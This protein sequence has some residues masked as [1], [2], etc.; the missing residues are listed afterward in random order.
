MPRINPLRLRH[1]RTKQNLSQDDL[2]RQSGIDKGTIFRIEA[3][4]C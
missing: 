1:Y 4:K 3:G 2:S